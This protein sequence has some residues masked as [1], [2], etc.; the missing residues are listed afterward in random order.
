M[1]GSPAN[2]LKHLAAA[3]AVVAGSLAVQASVAGAATFR[4]PNPYAY[5]LADDQIA[6]GT[7]NLFGDSFTALDRRPFPNW[8]EQLAQTP[9]TNGDDEVLRLAGFPKSGATAGKYK[10]SGNNFT[11]QVNQWLG[12]S[13]KFA[14]NDLTA[15][16]L[17]YNDIDGGTNANGSDLANAKSNYTAQL[18][19][20]VGAGANGGSR[21]ILLIMP[22]NW[23]RSPFYQKTGAQTMRKRT[24]VWDNFVAKTAQNFSNNYGNIV[25]VDLFTAFERV[26]DDPRAFCFTNVTDPLPKGGDPDKYLYDYQAAGGQFHFGARGQALIKQVVQ[27]YLTRGWDWSN[28]YK[29]PTTAKQKLNADLD[30]G[31]VFT[32]PCQTASRAPS[33]QALAPQQAT[34]AGD[35]NAGFG[36]AWTAYLRSRGAAAP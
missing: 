9:N 35:L 10:G 34:G 27:Y 25:A 30:A 1:L 12:T 5:G 4:V 36:Q 26:Y 11:S 28:T 23:G 31:Q 29:T 19:R 24:I 6:V 7:L 8:A 16:Y 22:H 32:T 33:A 14:S 18:K 3:A 2:G 21:R 17:G 15:V 13:P 20:I